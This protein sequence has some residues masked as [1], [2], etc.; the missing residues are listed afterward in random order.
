MFPP[1]EF[2]SP[3]PFHVGRSN[4]TKTGSAC[5][6]FLFLWFFIF[7]IVVVNRGG[8]MHCRLWV[9][10]FLVTST[11]GTRHL[12]TVLA[13]SS[14]S[15]SSSIVWSSPA[16]GDRF[17][18]GDTIIGKWQ[19]QPQV[20]S[21]SFRLCEGGENG[22]GATVWPEVKES[23]GSYLVSVTA[24]NVTSESAFYLQMKD[25]FGHG[26][27]SP[28]FNLTRDSPTRSCRPISVPPSAALVFLLSNNGRRCPC[29]SS[30]SASPVHRPKL[31]TT[32]TSEPL[33]AA[34]HNAPPAAALAVPLSL[35]GAIILLAGG[36]ALHHRRQLAA[37]RKLARE[38]SCVATTR[39]WWP[40]PR[41]QAFQ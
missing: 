26:Y 9:Y 22:C 13:Q 11:L 5:I 23:A 14:E 15:S 3:I 41:P 1:L 37:E 31:R 29:S 7:I 28:I 27:S 16:P 18:P 25:D 35:A 30:S 21:P 24:P 34:V 2:P 6:F 20:V 19:A 10:F 4:P 40:R 32:T 8:H 36:L 33:V 17:E 38:N 12:A 39:R